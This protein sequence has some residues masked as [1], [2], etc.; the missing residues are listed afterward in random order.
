MSNQQDLHEINLELETAKKMIARSDALKRL[1]ANPDWQLLIDDGYFRDYA[2]SRI[3]LR[4]SENTP[5]DIR[6]KLITDIDGIGSFKKFLDIVMLNGQ[7]A[8]SDLES[9]IA[10][11]DEIELED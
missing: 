9:A 11:R 10:T 4:A 6:D 2:V 1:E 7:Q 3:M 8:A 5:Q